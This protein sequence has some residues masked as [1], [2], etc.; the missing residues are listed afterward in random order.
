LDE[1]LEAIKEELGSPYYESSDA[2]LYQGDCVELMG[3]LSGSS[4]DLT[5]T[6][7]PYNIG[8]EYERI[9]P[10]AEYVTWCSKWMG[11]VY[12]LTAPRGSFWLNVGYVPVPDSGKAVLR[13]HTCCGIKAPST[14]FKK[15]YGT[16]EQE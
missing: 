13:S 12:E 9:L 5:V 11:Q 4:I 8:K 10:L 1:R 14:L 15:W 3:R 7:P 16:T 2:L 6:S